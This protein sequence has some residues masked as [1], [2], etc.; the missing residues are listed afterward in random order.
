[1]KS[2]TINFG[3]WS[4]ECESQEGIVGALK[5]ARHFAETNF[6][7]GEVT[8]SEKTDFWPLVVTVRV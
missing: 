2:Y 1:M 7:K 6:F 5:C 3:T 4:V 8:I